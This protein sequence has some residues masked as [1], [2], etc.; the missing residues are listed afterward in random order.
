MSFAHYLVAFTLV[1]CY[2][3]N[4]RGGNTMEKVCCFAGHSNIY[5]TDEHYKSLSEKN[6]KSYN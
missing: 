1:L 3:T 4:K 5:Y 2:N 6:R